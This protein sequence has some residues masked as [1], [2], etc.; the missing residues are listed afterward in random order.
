MGT[1]I[2]KPITVKAIKWTGL[3]EYEMFSLLE[4]ISYMWYRNQITNTLVFDVWSKGM[5][6]RLRIGDVVIR[7]E[8]DSMFIN[9]EK[10]FQQN[11][12]LVED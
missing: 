12:E 11:Y 10:C 1:Y 3:N 2:R 7:D 8:Q 9:T 4:G 6:V 5:P